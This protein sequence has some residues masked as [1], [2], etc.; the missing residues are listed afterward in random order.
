MNWTG[1]IQVSLDD[2]S[3]AS[4]EACVIVGLFAEL[5]VNRDMLLREAALASDTFYAPQFLITLQQ[6]MRLHAAGLR[7]GDWPEFSLKAGSRLHLTAY[8]IVGYAMLSSSNLDHALQ[9]ARDY[10]PLLNMKFAIDHRVVGTDAVIGFKDILPFAGSDRRHAMELEI[11][12][13]VRLLRD[14]LGDDF[15]PHEIRVDFPSPAQTWCERLLGCP[16]RC[17]AGINEIRFDARLLTGSL[18]QAQ[19]FTYHNCLQICD[20][21]MEGLA[22]ARELPNHIKR[23][24]LNANGRII[25]L[26]EVADQLCMS[27]R[28]LRRR[29]ESENTSYLKIAEE[30]RKTMAVRYL[31]TTSL[32]TEIIAE[33]LGYSDAA[34]FRHAFK[35]WTGHSPRQFRLT[36]G[37]A[38]QLPRALRSRTTDFI[39]PSLSGLAAY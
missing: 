32:T 12:K 27:P 21:M 39:K 33:R 4:T 6:Q 31:S 23:M 2:K 16:M 20:S 1:K 35:R 22:Q 37:A 9:V 7:C 30:V 10:A 25:T 17:N 11:A 29:L 5:G 14:V 38:P 19:A 26:P 3:F 8:G 36:H 28:T 15:T 24:L 34:N 13:T 18:P